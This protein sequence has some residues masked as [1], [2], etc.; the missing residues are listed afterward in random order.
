MPGELAAKNQ[1][2]NSWLSGDPALG[3]ARRTDRL[4]RNEGFRGYEAEIEL[5]RGTPTHALQPKPVIL[6]SG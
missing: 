2:A 1:A 6:P 3:L 5:T 4:D